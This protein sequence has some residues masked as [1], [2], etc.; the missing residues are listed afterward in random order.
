MIDIHFKLSYL[1]LYLIIINL[2]AFFIY[3]FDKIQ[4]IKTKKDTS[5]ISEFNLLFAAFLGGS[6]ASLLAMLLFRHKI[7]KLS[8][9]FKFIAV[10][11]AQSIIVYIKFKYFE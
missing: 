6:I 4:A 2:F 10:I 5:R 9:I 3:G 1:E 7:K 8:F 11:I